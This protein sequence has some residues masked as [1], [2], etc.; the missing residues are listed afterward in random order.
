[1]DGLGYPGCS[2]HACHLVTVLEV[3]VAAV[4]EDENH[5]ENHK[6]IPLLMSGFG[7]SAHAH[8]W[9]TVPEAEGAPVWEDR[10][11]VEDHDCI[12][13]LMVRPWQVYSGS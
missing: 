3:G 8:Q 2:V 7:Y 4:W 9:V 11:L 12:L 5:V 10:N 6:Y 13:P 1:M